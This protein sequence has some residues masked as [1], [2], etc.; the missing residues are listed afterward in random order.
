MGSNLIE[1]LRKD[2]ETNQIGE[3]DLLI[4]AVRS[5]RY[6]RQIVEIPAF[7]RDWD[8]Q[9]S[10]LYLSES[11]P[12]EPSPNEPRRYLLD[13]EAMTLEDNGP[14]GYINFSGLRLLQPVLGY[15]HRRFS[16]T[17]QTTDIDSLK[18]AVEANRVK[19]GDILVIQIP[20]DRR[21]KSKVGIPMFV[22]DWDSQSSTLSLSDSYLPSGLAEI[23]RRYSL[24]LGSGDTV[25]KMPST[26]PLRDNGPDISPNPNGFKIVQKVVSFVPIHVERQ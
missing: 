13:T 23:R 4:L 1:C 11:Y 19:A 17:E 9:F 2:I 22:Q 8:P 25:D 14:D 3:G 21:N 12:S 10:V 15:A 20:L 16:R 26:R 24:D 7:A 5:G 6:Q 18:K